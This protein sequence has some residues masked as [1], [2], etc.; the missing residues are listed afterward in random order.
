MIA[1][2]VDIKFNETEFGTN[3]LRKMLR[4]ELGTISGRPETRNDLDRGIV[5]ADSVG[6]E[7]GSDKLYYPPV[8]TEFF[9]GNI[10]DDT[11]GGQISAV[12]SRRAGAAIASDVPNI[13]AAKIKL[14]VGGTPVTIATP[15][16]DSSISVGEFDTTSAFLR[17]SVP[18]GEVPVA[19]LT[20]NFVKLLANTVSDS[21]KFSCKDITGASYAVDPDGNMSV[22]G[23]S[24][25]TSY[26]IVVGSGDTTPSAT[27]NYKLDQQI[28]K[29]FDNGK[30]VYG[31]T[32]VGNLV[33]PTDPEWSEFRQIPIKRSFLNF[34]SDSVIIKE[35][36]LVG[37]ADGHNFLLYR[38]VL[39]ESEW[40]DV[41]KAGGVRITINM[42]F[43][44]DAT[45]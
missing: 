33:T 22:R 19:G 31:I 24:G 2:T 43:L 41:P 35:I 40:I 16:F 25:D 14:K 29:G 45:E 5:F 1:Q 32:S 17:F 11:E 38:T 37:R 9:S 39:P 4:G 21:T 23:L 44:T 27:D 15:V 12:V 30:L 36:G 34:E 6:T 7:I 8:P 13:D 20:E 28:D 42:M 26:G 18:T 10:I 3:V